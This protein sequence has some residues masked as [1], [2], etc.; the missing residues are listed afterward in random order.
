MPDLIRHPE[1]IENTGFRPL[2][3]WRQIGIFDFLR[4]HHYF[5]ENESVAQEMMH[6][7]MLHNDGG[8]DIEKEVTRDPY[9]A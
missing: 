2:P 3:E 1:H 9:A 5:E 4:D 8:R 6:H 7:I